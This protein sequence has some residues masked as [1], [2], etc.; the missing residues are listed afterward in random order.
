MS[1]NTSKIN[2]VTQGPKSLVDILN[3]IID[4][5]N[6]TREITGDGRFIAVSNVGGTAGIR[7]IGPPPRGDGKYIAVLT[8]NALQSGHAAR[9]DYTFAEVRLTATSYELV[10][11][12]RTGTAI[13]IRELAHIAEPG[14]T[15]AWYVWGVQSHSGV[16]GSSYPASFAPRPVGGGGT[17]GTHKTDI[18]VELT[19]RTDS[20]GA[21]R[22]TFEAV[23]SHDGTCA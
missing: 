20:T 9:W 18:V 6:E 14:S 16:T 7:Y 12:G 15:V 3:R 21:R 5:V 11:G 13:N 10:S 22:Y 2:R 1:L 19:E 4:R 23:G 17:S 8:A